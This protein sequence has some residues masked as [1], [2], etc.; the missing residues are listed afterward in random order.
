MRED[1]FLVLLG[2]RKAFEGCEMF[3]WYL[4]LL[5]RGIY[6]VFPAGVK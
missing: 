5:G 3:F 4:C 1:I 6:G 2:F